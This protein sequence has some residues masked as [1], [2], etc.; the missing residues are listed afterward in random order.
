MPVTPTT[1]ASPWPR[2]SQHQISVWRKLTTKKGRR[3]AKQALVEG[4]RQVSE[5]LAS[6]WGVQAIL[7]SDD[8]QGHAAYK[9]L[10]RAPK[11]GQ[12]PTFALPPRAFATLTDTVHAPGI[13][14]CLSWSLPSFNAQSGDH[15][16]LK[17]VLI[18]D[19]IADPGNV[20]TLIR[21]AAALGLDGVIL[22]A[23]TVELANPKTLRSAAGAYFHIPVFEEI[24]PATIGSWCT[25]NAVQ[26]LVADAHRGEPLAT[27]APAERWAL[28][29]GAETIPL[30]PYWETVPVTWIRLPLQ[31]QVESLNAAVAGAIIMDRLTRGTKD[32]AGGRRR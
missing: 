20:G 29:V 13:A 3:E 5:A 23:G 4:V 30:D 22:C 9:R 24:K 1:P 27:G 16:A 11:S 32:A 8:P 10:D 18:C 25:K 6:G 14:A 26:L 21:T 12:V 19:R 15:A 2:A 31:R 7:V 28:V 17:R